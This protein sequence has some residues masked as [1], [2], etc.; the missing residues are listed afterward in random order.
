VV[1]AADVDA[2][3]D[4]RLTVDDRVVELDARV[5]HPIR[6]RAAPAQPSRIVSSSSAAA[7]RVDLHISQPSRASS[8]ISRRV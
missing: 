8:A 2:E 4:A 7:R 1:P 5:Q 6:I 3:G